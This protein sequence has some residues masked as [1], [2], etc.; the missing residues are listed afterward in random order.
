MWNIYSACGI[1]IP[2]EFHT[3]SAKIQHEH[4]PEYAGIFHNPKLLTEA[5]SSSESAVP[6]KEADR[7]WYATMWEKGVIVQT[8]ATRLPGDHQ[9]SAEEASADMCCVRRVRAP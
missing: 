1:F 3:N 8:F 5:R 6:R 7:R 4:L 2:H 9:K